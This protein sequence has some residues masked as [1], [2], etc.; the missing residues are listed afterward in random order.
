V[1]DNIKHE[2]RRPACTR[3]SRKQSD[4]SQKRIIFKP[5]LKPVKSKHCSTTHL[6]AINTHDRCCWIKKLKNSKKVA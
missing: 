1:T 6:S 2:H 3:P 5:A 4:Y